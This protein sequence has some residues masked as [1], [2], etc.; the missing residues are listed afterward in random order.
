MRRGWQSCPHWIWDVEHHWAG[1]IDHVVAFAEIGPVALAPEGHREI[2]PWVTRD[3]GLHPYDAAGT[4]ISFQRRNSCR[5]RSDEANEGRVVP[6]KN[7]YS[8]IAEVNRRQV[9]WR[10]LSVSVPVG[11]DGILDKGRSPRI[12]R[13]E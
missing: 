8:I 11:S 7:N 9:C 1:R 4:D 12:V 10:K 5:V 2:V 13:L 6:V 3:G